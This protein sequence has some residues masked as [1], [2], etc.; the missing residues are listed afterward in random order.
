MMIDRPTQV[1]W[2]RDPQRPSAPPDAGLPIVACLALL[3]L[4]GCSGGGGG[5][6]GGGGSPTT[7][8]LNDASVQDGAVWQINREIVL[9]FS[10][11]VDF[12]TVSAN[13]INIRSTSDVPAIGVF[14]PGSPGDPDGALRV[15]FQPNCPTLDDFSDAGLQPGG[16]TYVLR[17]PGKNSSP[18]TLRSTRGVPLGIQQT[19]TFVTPASN[20]ASI[21]FQDGEVGPPRA[22]V[23]EKNS[24]DTST[25]HAVVGGDPDKRVFFE[26]DGQSLGVSDPDDL[27]GDGQADTFTSPLN[28]YSDL[29]SRIGFVIAFNQPVSPSAGNISQDRIRLEFFDTQDPT[30]QNDG[31]WLPI[32][33]RVTLLTNCTEAGSTVLLEPVGVLPASGDVRAV[34]LPGFRDL[35]GDAVQREDATFALLPT[36]AVEFMT[37]DPKNELSD[38]FDEP[39]DFGGDSPLSFQD[40]TALFD[41]PEADWGDG[42]LSAAFSFEGTGG[43]GGDFDW[44]VRTGEIFFFDTTNTP[45]N[46]GPGGIPTT[47]Q[48][49]VNGVLDV[50]NLTVE[51]LGEIR[52]QGPNPMR[53]NATGEVRIEGRI[54]LA[55]F[56]AKDVATLNTGNQ[57]ETGGAGA[58]GGGRG[59]HAN[60]NITGPTPRGGR[61]QG[62]F[63]QANVGG[64]G[65]E[66]GFSAAASKNARRPGGGGGGRFTKDWIGTFSVNPTTISLAA[67]PGNNGNNASNG[68]DPNDGHKPSRGGS[69]GQGPFLDTSDSNDFFGVRPIVV[70]GVLT[71]LVRGELPSLWAGYGGGGGGN[72]G[73][74]FPNPNWNFNSDEKG[75]GGGGGGGGL[76]IKALGRIVFGRSAQVFAGGGRGATGENTNFLDHIGGTGGGGSGGHV[77]LESA[78]QVDFTNGGAGLDD[79]RREFILSNGPTRKEGSVEDVDTC[80]E[81]GLCCPGNCNRNS[82]GGPGGAG[83]IQIHVPDPTKPP[84]PDPSADIRVPMSAIDPNIPNIIDAITS[85]PAFIM[86]PTF[87]KRSKARSTW[88]SIGGADRKPDG[89]EGLVRF[90]FDGIDTTNGRI[91]TEGSTVMERTPLVTEDVLAGSNQARILSDGFTMEFFGPAIDAIRAGSTSGISNDVYLR[92][93]ALL[94]DCAV[95]MLIPANPANFEDFLIASAVYEEGAAAAGDEILRVTVG[96]SRPLTAFNQDGSDGV[97][98]FD[99]LP[100]FFQVVTSGVPNNLPSTAFVALRFQAAKDNGAGF[101]DEKNILQDWTS[102]ISTFNSKPAGALQ[103]FRY[104]VE[105]DL[106]KDSEGIGS[107]TAPVTLDFLKIPFVF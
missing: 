59:G 51:R 73:R 45:I 24:L 79:N 93:P 92:T 6:G 72:A 80:G 104:E 18:N 15:I 31:L 89:S 62:P 13:T 46:G 71:G 64:Q 91:L 98:G 53:I 60:E 81:S 22:L 29:E 9:T 7:F 55:G 57:V 103:F 90:F 25:T 3:A 49:A 27:D 63:K 86:I 82:N 20:Q 106:D 30:N 96:G 39:Y 14:R 54:E 17:I 47:T 16:V 85:P 1:P 32:E 101:P 37:L 67:G 66:M 83:L 68:A 12:S 48:N 23:R 56:N 8:Q 36:R 95:R 58:A 107:T 52:V 75:G 88:I 26:K 65:G 74:F 70:D 38:A 100:R 94:Q 50:R 21:V 76:H 34:L 40:T 44:I 99:L 42:R 2:T 78:T 84:S 11:A 61:G 19:R 35:V 105:F 10:E 41:T 102:D 28:L 4:A 87:G 77:V 43:P 5:G 97:T 69:P 33:T